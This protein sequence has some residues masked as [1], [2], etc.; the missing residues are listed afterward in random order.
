M[1]AAHA[2]GLTS[3]VRPYP[4]DCFEGDFGQLGT[5]PYDEQHG[6]GGV[7]AAALIKMHEGL[8]ALLGAVEGHAIGWRLVVASLKTLLENPTFIEARNALLD[9]VEELSSPHLPAIEGVI[10]VA[11]AQFGMGRNALRFLCLRD[12]AEAQLLLSE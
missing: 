7:F 2:S 5:F 6:A 12:G 3:G 8:V 11:F 9:C 10:W 4:Y 1:F